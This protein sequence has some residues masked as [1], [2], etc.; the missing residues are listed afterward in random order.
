[1]NTLFFGMMLS[2]VYGLLNSV[3]IYFLEGTSESRH[4]LAAYNI[5][6]KTLISFGLILGTAL[7][8]FRSQ[9]VIPQTIEAAFTDNQLQKTDYFFYKHRFFSRRRSLTFSAEFAAVGFLI[10]S[11]CQFPLHGLAEALMIIPACIQYALGVYVGRK[12][13]YAGMMLHSLSGI[14]VSRNLFKGRELDDINTYVHIVSTLTIVFGYVHLVGY[15][16]GP[17]LYHSALGEGVKILLMLP[18]LIATPVLLI[19]NFY[20]RAVLRKLYSKSI[21][22]E[23]GGLQEALQSEELSS[24]EKRSYLLQ[25]DRMSREELRYSLQL[26]LSDLPI[27]ITIFVMLLESLLGK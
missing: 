9:N 26:T 7:V 23:V 6:F 15:S 27:G 13:F 8:V 21:D 12:L 22:V 3:I 20:P 1:M 19:F 24:F 11:Y 2:L 17:F 10:F 16:R 14:T 5:S 25:F 18:A 4:F